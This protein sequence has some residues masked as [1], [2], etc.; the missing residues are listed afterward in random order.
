MKELKVTPGCK[1]DDRGLP[2]SASDDDCEDV[3]KALIIFEE[4]DLIELMAEET[5]I[6]EWK[7]GFFSFRN[8][9][10]DCPVPNILSHSHSISLFLDFTR[11]R[12]F[13]GSS[14][15]LDNNGPRS[16]DKALFMFPT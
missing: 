6:R 10:F 1:K 2:L 12:F 4:V 5:L 15:N 3:F 11:R 13:N 7:L 8:L 16:A 9:S 14:I